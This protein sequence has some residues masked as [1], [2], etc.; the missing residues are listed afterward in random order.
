MPLLTKSK[1]FKS[2]LEV[3][4]KVELIMNNA[5]DVTEILE[6]DSSAKM[7]N[8]K[9]KNKTITPVR[10]EDKIG[11][12]SYSL[13]APGIKEAYKIFF[14]KASQ[15]SGTSSQRCTPLF[16][17]IAESNSIIGT[18]THSKDKE[19]K[20]L[21]VEKYDFMKNFKNANKRLKKQYD[22]KSLSYEEDCIAF[23]KEESDEMVKKKKQRKQDT[24]RSGKRLE[25][26]EEKRTVKKTKLG[27]EISIYERMIM[28]QESRNTGLYALCDKC[29]KAR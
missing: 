22:L 11:D 3:N 23:E 9:Q 14:E 27:Q 21:N 8:F 2:P 7:E 26:K 15:S 24:K 5:P 25:N 28:I 1:K 17:G 18:P 20:S 6:K 16:D 10:S 12:L 13:N 19:S 4:K 29:N